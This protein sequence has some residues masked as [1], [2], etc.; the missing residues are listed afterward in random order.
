MLAGELERYRA[1]EAKRAADRERARETRRAIER[2]ERDQWAAGHPELAAYLATADRQAWP[3]FL[4]D[5]ADTAAREPLTPRQAEVATRIMREQIARAAQR[6][7]DD[8]TAADIPSG[9]VTVTGE[10]IST[11][12]EDNPYS[13]RGGCTSRML[14]RADDGWRVWVTIP[15]EINDINATTPGNLGGLHG[16]RVRFTCEITPKR[17]ERAFGYG[18]RPRKAEVLAPATV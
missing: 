7:E 13:P 11:R 3:G 5:M 8:A 6:A 14:V 4:W 10:V 9:T 16:A 2:A 18:K 15:R 1:A 17:G 12:L